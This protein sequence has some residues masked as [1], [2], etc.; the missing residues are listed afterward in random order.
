M[1]RRADAR[2][3]GSH[4]SR[5]AFLRGT[6]ATGALAVFGGSVLAACG[7][8]DE[9]DRTGD[10]AYDDAGIDW[11]AAAGTTI[12]IAVIPATYFENLLDLDG[13]FEELTG[14]TLRSEQIP[15][16]EIRA[17]VIRDLS[18]G[19]GNFHT[20]AADPMYYPLYVANDWIEPLEGFLEDPDLTNPEWFDYEDI[21]E[22]WR[23]AAQLDGVTYGIP[24]DGE[25]TV[26]VY[27]ADLFEEHG[28]SPAEDFDQ[29]RA[30]A[31]AMHDPDNRLWGTALRGFP[32]A[33]QNMYIYPSLFRAW[34]GEWFD[35]TGNPTVNSDE[36]VAALDYY[37]E[38]LND[39]SPSAVVNWNWPDIADAFA[40]GTLGSY[41]DAH[42]SAAV[43][44]DPATSVVGDS[45]G[46]ARWPQG[47]GG[48]R[49]TSIWNWSYPINASVSDEEKRAT[50]LFIQWATSRETQIRTSFAHPGD[51]PRSGVNRVSIWEDDRFRDEVDAGE[52]FIDAALTSL[53]DDT[54]IDWRP[55]VP[56]WPEIGDRMAVLIQ[57]AL[58]RQVTPQEA[59]DQ[60][61]REIEQILES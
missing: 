3:P 6:A 27:R 12:N 33:G 14:I 59:L 47:P 30:N 35:D 50:W 28:L 32:G 25:V 49:V 52:N 41:I 55:R 2:P 15:P 8:A 42:S 60:A 18:T 26:Q 46:F 61:N 13:E 20:H 16:G 40:V 4:L 38:L 53:Q 43:L 54:D 19:T 51:T 45:L 1:E 5:R 34:G 36:A 24:Y 58:T 39:L 57:E 10:E 11:R 31:E 9:E 44:L 48:R 29:Y 23:E 37:V 56:Q 17:E 21:F 7:D 22:M